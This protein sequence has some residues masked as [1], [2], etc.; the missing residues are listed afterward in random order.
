MNSPAAETIKTRCLNCDSTL[1]VKSAV[2]GKKVK[3][4]KC[5]Q[6]FMV[7]EIK[8][9]GVVP[10]NTSSATKKS[11]KIPNEV[12]KNNSE[13][14]PQPEFSQT[15]ENETPPP[16]NSRPAPPALQ[17]LLNCDDCGCQV[18]R[19]ASTCPNCG[20]P[21][22]G[23]DQQQT[24]E[25]SSIKANDQLGQSKRGFNKVVSMKVSI[26]IIGG[27]FGLLFLVVGANRLLNPYSDIKVRAVREAKSQVKN[28]STFKLD[29]ITFIEDSDNN[30]R[31][32][33]VVKGTAQNDFGATK[34]TTLYLTW[35][36][37]NNGFVD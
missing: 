13:N 23:L 3:C 20:A 18:S 6:P 36:H 19:R 32:L 12:R 14:K 11:Q 7:A 34:D 8:N 31:L 26:L 29:E 1:R 17:K 15:I 33:V 27:I 5:E 4:P 22:G 30:D 9:N 10:E 16:L 2:I 24:G 28:P 25:S 37:R 21:V 35:S